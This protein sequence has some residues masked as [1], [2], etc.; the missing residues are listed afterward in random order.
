MVKEAEISCR[1]VVCIFQRSFGG[2]DPC[3]S[4]KWDRALNDIGYAERTLD[5]G[6][7]GNRRDYIPTACIPYGPT[8]FIYCKEGIKNPPEETPSPFS[9]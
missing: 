6:K 2:E 1:D 8:V 4:L 5:R 3:C 7:T 9:R